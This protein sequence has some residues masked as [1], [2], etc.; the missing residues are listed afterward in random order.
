MYII[1]DIFYLHY[2]SFKDARDLIL[3]AK[4]QGLIPGGD[5]ARFLSDFTGDAYRIILEFSVSS[6][7]KYETELQDSMKRPEWQAWYAKFKVFV[8]AG[9]REILKVIV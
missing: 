9:N 5:S 7:G 3:D 1:R 4:N 8:R 2:G 6:L